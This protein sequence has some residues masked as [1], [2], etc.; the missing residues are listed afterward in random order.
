MAR[1]PW[2]KEEEELLKLQYPAL[3]EEELLSLFPGRSIHS[4]KRKANKFGVTK[5]DIWTEEELKVVEQYEELSKQNLISRLPGR[6]WV[7]IKTMA[8]NL[9]KRKRFK[10]TLEEEKR[11]K[12]VYFNL[13]KQELIKLFPDTTWNTI[14]TKACELDLTGKRKDWTEEEKEILK[15]EYPNYPGTITKEELQSLLSNRTWGSIVGKAKKLGIN[16][17]WIWTEEE[18]NLLKKYYPQCSREEIEK[19]LPHRGWDAI[20][21]QTYRLGLFLGKKDLQHRQNKI[22][23]MIDQILNEKAIRNKRYHW[24]RSPKGWPLEIDGFYPQHNL[25]VEHQ[26]Q[27]HYQKSEF[28]GHKDD[29]QYQQTCD[30]IKR[31]AIAQKGIKLLEIKYDEPLTEEHLRER[32]EELLQLAV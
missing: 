16:A 14:Q 8:H 26:G 28:L 29:L 22:L 11:L 18:N 25:A 5:R 20:T 12:R 10:W 3:I 24:M 4:L 15:R 7:A 21:S 1:Q 32:V 27:Q 9:G 31:V 19:L 17:N 2:T 23:D 13:S 30:T 6:S